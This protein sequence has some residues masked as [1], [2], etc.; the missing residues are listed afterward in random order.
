M[1]SIFETAIFVTCSP[2]PLI[3][4]SRFAFISSVSPGTPS[5]ISGSDDASISPTLAF[6]ISEASPFLDSRAPDT[7]PLISVIFSATSETS[8]RL[9]QIMSVSRSEA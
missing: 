3:M 1:V 6:I 2:M 7:V 8:F 9:L 4:A 5:G